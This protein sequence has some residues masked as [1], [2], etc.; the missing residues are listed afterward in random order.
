MIIAKNNF[1]TMG[2]RIVLFPVTL[3]FIAWISP[4]NPGKEQQKIPNA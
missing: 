3:F 2:L 4:I 1:P